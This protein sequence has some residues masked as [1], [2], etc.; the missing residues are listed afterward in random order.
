MR[1]YSEVFDFVRDTL[2]QSSYQCGKRKTT[3]NYSR[4]NHIERVYGWEQR[5]LTELSADITIH[6]EALQLATIFHDVGY[7]VNEGNV[8]HAQASAMICKEYLEQK[9]YDRELIR[10][11]IYLVENHSN[12][13]LLLDKSTPIELIVLMEAD[14]L[15]DM[16]A[17][18]LVM[19]TMIVT[20]KRKPDF[21]KVYNHMQRY[22]VKEMKENPMVTEPARRF[23]KEKQKLTEEFNLQLKM[24][25]NI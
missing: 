13:E 12:K 24:D 14:L 2:E 19:D 4:F 22:A 16:G 18:A 21:Y 11:I 25:L 17:L 6:K 5:I 8:K 10:E 23:W 7:G 1:E 20:K 3:I 15:D 9:G